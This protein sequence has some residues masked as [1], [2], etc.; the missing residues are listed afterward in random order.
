MLICGYV[1]SGGGATELYVMALLRYGDLMVAT[2]GRLECCLASSVSIMRKVGAVVRL[3]IDCLL[4]SSLV[5]FACTTNQ[6]RTIVT[7]SGKIVRASDLNISFAIDKKYDRDA[8]IGMLRSDDPAGIASRAKRMGI[9]LE[10]ALK[11]HAYANPSELNELVEKLVENRFEKD[12]LAIQAA[13]ADFETEWRNLLPLFSNIVVETTE[14]PWVHAEYFCVVS[15]FHP[16]ISDWFGNK[17]AVKYDSSSVFK[18]RI[19]AHEI[20]LSDVFQ[21]LRKRYG[22]SEIGD[23]QVW[24]FSEITAVFILNNARLQAFWPDFP[25]AGDYF[26]K[27]NYPQLSDLEGQL[28]E[29]F[30]QRSSYMDY[31][32]KS[33]AVLKVFSHTHR[34]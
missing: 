13:K 26:S 32:E 11:I 3:R 20:L 2:V 33:A 23:W 25:H 10:L 15:S 22:R 28:K 16:G 31:E 8:I 4:I 9:D 18:R 14:A 17:V 29:L 34:E 12:G 7:P 24:A 27:S 6:I 19:L 5:L 21:L 30:D 1:A